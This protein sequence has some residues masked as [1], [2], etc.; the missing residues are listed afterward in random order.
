M[1]HGVDYQGAQVFARL[2]P[3]RVRPVLL[4]ILVP[5]VGPSSR[6]TPTFILVVRYEPHP[7]IVVI[8]VVLV[9][10]VPLLGF[11]RPTGAPL[12]G[13]TMLLDPRG[14]I[15]LRSQIGPRLYRVHIALSTSGH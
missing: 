8:C 3:L 2:N 15:V 7:I 4:R 5:T 13:K 14:I 11:P 6:L 1:L 12:T 9:V 10:V